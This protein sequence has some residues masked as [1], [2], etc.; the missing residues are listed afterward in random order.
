LIWWVGHGSENSAQTGQP[1]TSMSAGELDL[2]LD[3]IGCHEMYIFLG[4][5]HSGSFIDD[6]TDY[7]HYRDPDNRIIFTACKNNESSH[8][9]TN[10]QGKSISRWSYQTMRAID[11][12]YKA[13]DADFTNDNRVSL[14]EIFEFAYDYCKSVQTPQK[15]I[16]DAIDWENYFI[17]D[18]Y[19]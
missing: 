16:G 13:S 1:G 6:L 19:Y 18:G 8:V 2:A 14:Y 11:P 12:D 7:D 3:M 17:Y 5:C 4:M 15:W 9:G 10:D